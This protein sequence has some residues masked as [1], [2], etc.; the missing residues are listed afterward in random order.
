M[1]DVGSGAPSAG[2]GFAVVVVVGFTVVVV[3]FAV[4]VVGFT[5]V[6]GASVVVGGAAVVP[7]VGRRRP[8][9][10]DRG[11][12][13]RALVDHDLR[14]HGGDGGRGV[15]GGGS[16]ASSASLAPALVGG[17]AEVVDGQQRQGAI[18]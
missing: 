10:A 16:M 15:G 12:T 13:D 7:V 1:A 18:A 17:G 8:W 11:S 2:A 4:V 6:V 3:G 14:P 5:V 9:L